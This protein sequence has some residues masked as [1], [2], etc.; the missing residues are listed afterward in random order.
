MNN[1]AERMIAARTERLRVR[2]EIFKLL[3]ANKHLL[4]HDYF[5]TRKMNYNY[6]GDL[7]DLNL[8]HYAKYVT[9]AIEN[10]I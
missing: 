4:K 9:E 5:I 8:I 7:S 10:E 6:M 1:L 3:R 2:R